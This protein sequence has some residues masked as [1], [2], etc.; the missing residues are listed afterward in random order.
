MR[1][2]LLVLALLFSAA[3]FAETSSCDGASVH[4]EY[5]PAEVTPWG[6]ESVALSVSRDGYSVSQS[7]EYVHFHLAC[8]KNEQDK[9][10]IVY[11]AYCSGSAC[12]DGDNW[13]IIDPDG[14]EVLLEPSDDNHTKAERIFGGS[15]TPFWAL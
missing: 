4:V 3:T 11:Q 15:L 6:W 13:G 10:Y 9:S 12:R 1:G 14:V 7:Y 8:L 2:I 5:S